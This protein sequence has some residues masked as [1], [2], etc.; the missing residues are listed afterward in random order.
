MTDAPRSAWRPEASRA[1]LAGLAVA[2]ASLVAVAWLVALPA[3]EVAESRALEAGR[4]L[5]RAEQRE[6]IE[7]DRDRVQASLA[8]ARVAS[9]SVLRV[10][11]HEADQAH[12]MRML[13][14]GTGADVGTQTIVAGDSLP[15]TPSADTPYRAVPVTVEMKATFA[16][17][18]EILARAENDS[19]LVRP[20]R[21]EIRR[22][23][24][25]GAPR[26]D[27][28]A[29]EGATLVEAVLELDAVYGAP[30]SGDARQARETTE[31]TP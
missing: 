24:D 2:T 30:S 3:L 28:A 15:A 20:I 10:I 19:R 7:R 16:R 13:A 25:R 27:A 4:L 21:V 29:S 11:P 5:G 18:M 8:D 9:A 17:V 6:R 31:D 14:V 1:S 23:A 12:L 26:G 22:P